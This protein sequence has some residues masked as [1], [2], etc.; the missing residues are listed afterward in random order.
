VIKFSASEV[1]QA[2]SKSI[3]PTVAGPPTAWAG[4]S[5][6]AGALTRERIRGSGCFLV[7]GTTMTHSV[8]IAGAERQANQK[9]AI[10]ERD[11]RKRRVE[12][13]V[14]RARASSPA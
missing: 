14:E 8:R 2:I 3:P 11:A 7:G 9:L 4:A 10:Y 1:A 5:P 12:N 6:V 13:V